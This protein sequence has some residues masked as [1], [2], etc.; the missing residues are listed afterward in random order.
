MRLQQPER[1]LSRV[2][3]L[4]DEGYTFHDS[5]RMLLPHHLHD[6]QEAERMLEKNLR[7]GEGPAE[8]LRDVGLS[9]ALL[10]PVGIAVSHGNLPQAIRTVS[11][12][13]RRR[14]KTMEKLRKA[15]LYPAVLFSFISLLFVLFRTMFLPNM[16]VMLTGRGGGGEAITLSSYLLKLPDA[17]AL[18]VGVIVATG[19]PAY[20]IWSKKPAGVRLK[21]ILSIPMM[22]RWFRMGHTSVFAREM[23]ALLG[24]GVPLQQAI[25]ILGQQDGQSMLSHMTAAIGRRILGGDPLHEAVA[26]TDGFMPD[27][28]SFIRHGEDSGHLPRELLVYSELMDEKIGEESEKLIA[29]VQPVLFGIL[30]VCIMGAYLALMLPVYSMIELQ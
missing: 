28:T 14:G 7:S 2:A 4:M 10:I 6:P 8:I 19:I 9:S 24:G 26:M 12:R 15:T 29:I 13:L 22:S 21:V 18:L 23:G 5:I 1:F 25:G 16:E 11:D 17:L 20:V 27:F 30:A 3:G